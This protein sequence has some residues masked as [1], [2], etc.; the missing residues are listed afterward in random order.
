MLRNVIGRALAIASLGAV[1]WSAP[2]Q[3][4][5]LDFENVIPDTSLY[6]D[7]ETFAQG[8]FTFT[9]QGDFGT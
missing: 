7:G 1:A 2:A 6:G 4:V 8:G 3:A 9:N 5:L